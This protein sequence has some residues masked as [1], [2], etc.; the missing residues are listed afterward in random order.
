MRTKVMNVRIQ[1]MAR[2]ALCGTVVFA[3]AALPLSAQ[4]VLLEVT[5]DAIGDQLGWSVDTVGD[6]DGDSHDDVIAGAPYADTAGADA[7][8]VMLISGRTGAVIRRHNGFS[9]EEHFGWAVAGVGGDLSGDGIPD[10]VVGAPGASP[11]GR[12]RAGVARAYSGANGSILWARAGQVA[13][14]HLGYAIDGSPDVNG[15]NRR[16][17]IVGSPGAPLDLTNPGTA[18]VLSGADGVPLPNLTWTGI[19]PGDRAGHSVAGIGDANR[20]TVPDFMIGAPQFDRSGALD[21]GQARIMSGAD[22]RELNGMTGDSRATHLGNSVCPAGDIELDG[23]F[24]GFVGAP[25]ERDRGRAHVMQGNG[26][27]PPTR[28]HWGFVR[29][30]WFGQAVGLAGDVDQDGYQDMIVGTPLHGAIPGI[31]GDNIPGMARILSG[32]DGYTLFQ[33][34]GFEH[35][36]W[37]GYSVAGAGDFNNDGFRDYVVGAPMSGNAEGKIHIFS[38][39]KSS[40]SALN[41]AISITNG[42]TQNMTLDAGASHAGEV[43]L[44]MGTMNGTRPGLNLG[45][46]TLPLN[47]DAYLLFTATQAGLPP[48]TGGVGTL[49][50]AGRANAAWG[51]PGGV[52]PTALLSTTFHHAF[53]TISGTT[54]TS[55]SNAIPLSLDV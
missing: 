32:R 47:L 26:F 24:E 35:M 10:Y 40:L 41:L 38:G 33:V 21:S 45:T 19:N 27:A 29:T 12:N 5:G 9:T 49:D 2:A 36:G 39:A 22:G 25:H 20:D 16:E 48:I 1:G 54:V 37:F 55:V 52:L 15:D 30:I 28:T 44:L 23:D 43:Y 18:R 11:S 50:A 8:M 17:V 3:A 7:G 46:V 53:V 14:D 34:E 4:Q 51:V 42:G 13:D 31:I 6:I